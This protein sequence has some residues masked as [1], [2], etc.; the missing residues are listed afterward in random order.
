MIGGAA[1]RGIYGGPGFAP[2]FHGKP[3]HGFGHANR[4]PGGFHQG[5]N[6]R[7]FGRHGH[8]FYGNG[9]YGS[10]YG[11]F[12]GYA[13]PAYTN[14]GG[15]TVVV[16]E[17][18]TAE[19]ISAMMVPT[20]VGIRR[21]P[22]ARPVIYSVQSGATGSVTRH[23]TQAQPVLRPSARVIERDGEEWRQAA[24]DEAQETGGGPRII[25]VRVP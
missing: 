4:G 5:M 9:Y 18:P 17:A 19:A 7:G 2:P 21:Q 20:V 1:A 6:H 15:N 16:N 23:E 24:T 12:P 22:E 14:G 3:A 8:G 25:E 11:Y 10:A 13:Y